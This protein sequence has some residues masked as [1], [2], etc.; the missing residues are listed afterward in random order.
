[1]EHIQISWKKNSSFLLMTHCVKVSALFSL[2]EE[3]L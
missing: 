3:L 1:M 2:S